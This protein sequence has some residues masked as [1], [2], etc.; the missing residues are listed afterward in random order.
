[1]LSCAVLQVVQMSINSYGS[2]RAFPKS[3][4]QLC[5]L[6]SLS[7]AAS[8]RLL[9]LDTGMAALPTTLRRIS[10]VNC[11]VKQ[12]LDRAQL[13]RLRAL[14]SLILLEYDWSRQP[15]LPAAVGELTQL[16]RLVTAADMPPFLANLTGLWEL[17]VHRATIQ[18]AADLSQ[19]SCLTGLTG[20]NRCM[21][22]TIDCIQLLLGG[23]PLLQVVSRVV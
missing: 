18:H 7:L 6:T 14:T 15:E 1:M 3:I 22:S 2:C 13:R 4:G 9:E 11:D 21:D 8:P 12:S 10:L 16:R 23:F 5:G 20:E 19:L 17:L